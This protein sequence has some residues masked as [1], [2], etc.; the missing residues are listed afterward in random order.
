VLVLVFFRSRSYH[1]LYYKQDVGNFLNIT[2]F[3]HDMLFFDK[4][5]DVIFD[6]KSHIS[7]PFVMKDLGDAKYILGMDIRRDREKKILWLI[8]SMYVE[9][10]VQHFCMEN[11]G[12]LSVL[13]LMGTKLSFKDVPTILIDMRDMYYIPN[14]DAIGT[15]MY[16]IFCTRKNTTQALGVL[17][18][19]MV[20]HRCE[21]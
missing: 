11:C 15:L 5:K 4:I 10:L 9:Y 8:H 3:V 13:I 7:E 6:V 17:N 18:Q 2:L 19:F 12:A 21:H 20:N 14:V 16:V 1:Y